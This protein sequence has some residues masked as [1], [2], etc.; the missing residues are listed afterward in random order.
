M[1]DF[2]PGNRPAPTTTD[3][4]ASAKD[5]AA[6]VAQ[7][8]KQAAGEVAQTASIAAKDVAQETKRQ[9]SDLLGKTRD[10]LTEQV[11]AQQSSLVDTLRALGEQLGAMTEDVHEDGTA[12]DVATKARDKARGAADWLDHRDPSEVLDE[13]RRFG[14]DRPAVFLLGATLAGVAAGRLT[15]GVVAAHADNRPDDSS[16]GSADP[17][18]G[19]AGSADAKPAPL[20]PIGTPAPRHDALTAPIPSYQPAQPAQPRRTATP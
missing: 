4:D 10:Q 5:K 11:S 1:T 3:D 2:S 20:P 17:S 8:G 14:R 16:G 12:V 9:A 13:I 15:R 19:I 6:D 18:G 7:S